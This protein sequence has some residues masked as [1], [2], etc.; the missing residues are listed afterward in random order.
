[1]CKYFFALAFVIL[2]FVILFLY[3]LFSVLFVYLKNL[4]ILSIKNPP[5]P[6]LY[7]VY[8]PGNEYQVVFFL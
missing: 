3:M 1:M 2:F 6:G 7:T 8:M 4:K 5:R